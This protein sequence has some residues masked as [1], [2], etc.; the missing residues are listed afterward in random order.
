MAEKTATGLP[1]GPTG[2]TATFTRPMDQY[3]R[4]KGVPWNG[5]GIRTVELFA[6]VG[7]F[8]LGLEA[9]SPVFDTVWFNQWEP[10]S[11]VQHAWNCYAGNHCP[12]AP[13]P[14][15]TNSDI[16][17]VPAS[18]I[19]EHDLLVGGFP[20]QDYSVATTLDK[21]GG[22]RGKKGVLWWEINRILHEKR[23][24]YVLLE[25]VDRLL[26][27]PASQRGRDF[28]VLLAC[29]RDLAYVVEWRVINAADY[30]NAQRRRRTFIFAAREDTAI[31]QSMMEK[32][33]DA[34]YLYRHGFFASAFPTS[35]ELL[36]DAANL[37]EGKL[38]AD[39]RK[40]SSSFEYLFQNAG[41]MV[42][43]NFWTKR[44]TPKTEPQAILG[45][46][47]ES[48]GVHEAYFLDPK[49]VKDWEYQKG[50]K[51]EKRTAKNGYEY[52]YSEGG[53]QFPDLHDAP[54]RTILTSEGNRT[55]N[56]STHVVQDPKTGRLRFLTPLEV[57]RVMGFPDGWTST[58][59]E[60]WRYFTMGNALVVPLVTRMG[61]QL[62][63]WIKS[64][65]SEE[66]VEKLLDGRRTLRRKAVQRQVQ[67]R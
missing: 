46:H 13:P 40:V 30:G 18:E 34:S 63:E 19:P 67:L 24:P 7:G 27:S 8:R 54:A 37:P 66:E 51:R 36:A 60:R 21:A 25:N 11:R 48:D 38:P 47:L 2:Q 62:T 42:D 15:S 57:E 31:G 43:G 1:T 3:M 52:H 45:K 41:I 26:K 16:C 33:A 58:L 20:C 12:G 59:P 29:L 64:H 44:V 5:M 22:L 28:G 10:A 23:P 9:A 35:Y 39:V 61:L 6:G 53:M 56:R 32:A 50:P 17:K 4:L 14:P 49:R 65:S 55:P